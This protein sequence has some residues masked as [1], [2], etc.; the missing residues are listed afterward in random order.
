MTS[1]IMVHNVGNGWKAGEYEKALCYW[2][3][4]IPFKMG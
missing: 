4:D 3:Y 1:Y 2:M